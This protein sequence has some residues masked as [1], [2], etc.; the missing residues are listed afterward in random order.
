VSEQTQF[1]GDRDST[2]R[3]RPTWTAAGR[4]GPPSTRRPRT[5]RRPGPGRA[6]LRP[7]VDDP[8][9]DLDSTEDPSDDPA[10]DLDSTEDPSDDPAED[11]DGDGEVSLE[12]PDRR[13]PPRWRPRSPNRIRYVSSRRAAAS[14]RR[15]VRIHSYAGYE[16]RVKTNL[17]NRISSLNM[18]DYIFQAEVPM[19]EVPEIKNGQKK[20]IRRVRIP[21]Y[22]W[23][24]W[25]SPTSPGERSGTPRCHRFRGAHPQT[26]AVESRRGLHH[27]GADAATGRDQVPPGRGEVVTSRWA[28]RSP[29]WKAPSRRSRRPSRDQPGCPEAQGAGF[30]LRAGDPVELS[31]PT[32]PRSDPSVSRPG[33]WTVTRRTTEPSEG[34]P[35]R[36]AQLGRQ[37]RSGPGAGRARRVEPG[38]GPGDMPPEEEGRSSHQAAD[39]RR[40]G[41]AAPPIAPL[42]GSTASTSWSSARRT[43]RRPRA[44]AAT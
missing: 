36:A 5:W 17:E 27:V 4:S 9:E 29:S 16:N 19:E 33:R 6:V 22:V 31:S 30:D 34:H 3:D 10:E 39:Q 21:G 44:S 40:P 12:G 11:L 32:S 8:A 2:R 1:P 35:E 18:E 28:R 41:D 38:E 42:W 7:G 15:L 23:C 24:G 20:Q 43:T 25:N 13:T 26:G 37:A 14:S